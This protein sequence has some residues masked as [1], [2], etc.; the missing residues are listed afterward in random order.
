[1]NLAPI[2]S[3]VSDANVPIE[4]LA[5][6]K[7]LTPQ[8]KI[9]EAS[10]QFEAILLRQ[11]LSEMQKPVITSEFTDDSTAAGI[12]QDTI[13]NTLA[14]SISKSGG[15]G[16]AKVFEDQLT[17]RNLK[18]N[19]AASAAHPEN[20]VVKNAGTLSAKVHE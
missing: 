1:M 6:N 12:Y 16:F 4:D 14:Q 15:V 17:P 2:Q 7:H 10:Q 19:Q 5:G 9:H 8:Q 3:P 11:I 18:H 13:S 20:Q